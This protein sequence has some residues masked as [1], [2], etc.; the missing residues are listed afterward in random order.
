MSKLRH[1]DSYENI[2]KTD[3]EYLN[4]LFPLTT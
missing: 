2:F 4:Q 1:I 3:R